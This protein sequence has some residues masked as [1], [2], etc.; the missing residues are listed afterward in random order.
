MSQNDP[1]FP[2]KNNKHSVLSIAAS[3]GMLF[4]DNGE[5]NTSYKNLAVYANIA[6]RFLP[7][8]EPE[9]GLTKLMKHKQLDLAFTYHYSFGPTNIFN[10]KLSFALNYIVET[11]LKYWKKKIRTVSTI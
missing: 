2:L 10:V 7:F 11:V 4:I 1:F 3:G 5:L 9:I 8:I 6:E